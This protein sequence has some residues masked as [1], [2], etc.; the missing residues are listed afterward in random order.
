MK[1]TSILSLVLVSLIGLSSHAESAPDKAAQFVAQLK[2]AALNLY[3]QYPDAGARLGEVCKL[4]DSNTDIPKMSD[5]SLGRHKKKFS[6]EQL[7]SFNQGFR[8]MLA[9]IFDL[10]FQRLKNGA[11]T[12]DPVSKAIDD[13]RVVS[14]TVEASGNHSA[15]RLQFYLSEA[16]K[17]K[18]L[19]FDASLNSLRIMLAKRS[20]FDSVINNAE[21]EKP[22][23]G[24]DALIADINQNNT[25]CP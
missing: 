15:T 5:F 21:Q 1:F 14:L 12:I 20:E 13:G 9:G 25:A 18:F 24:A 19:L 17:D 16:T 4:I 6:P 10:A 2:D 22:G 7:A 3:V 8:S 11:I 23:S